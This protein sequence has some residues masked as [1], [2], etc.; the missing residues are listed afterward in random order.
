MNDKIDIE[1]AE[2]EDLVRAK[3]WWKENGSSI[4]AGI[5]IGTALVVGYNYWQTYKANHAR[6]VA[7]LYETYNKTPQDTDALNQLLE[8]DSATMYSQLAR[9]ASAKQALEEENFEQAENMLNEVMTTSDD[10]GLQ[11]VAA[12]RLAAV[13]L[14]QDKSDQAIS[15]LDKQTVLTLPLMK[16]RIAE[17]KADANLKL[18]DSQ[19]AKDLYESSIALL[20]ESGQPATLVQLKLDNL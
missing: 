17:L 10:L 14:A 9:M 16:A 8:S 2:D 7:L 15:L 13:Y 20:T 6:E 11:S 5:V 19:K 4:I 3:A 12:L 1:L 18:G